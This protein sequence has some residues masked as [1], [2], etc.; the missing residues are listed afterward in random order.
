MYICLSSVT[1]QL[2]ASRPDLWRC[3]WVLEGKVSEWHIAEIRIYFF[4]MINTMKCQL[5]V[6]I[7]PT[8]LRC[9]PLVTVS[10]TRIKDSV[11]FPIL[12]LYMREFSH[13]TI[14]KV[15][16]KF[17]FSMLFCAFCKI[18]NMYIEHAWVLF[19]LDIVHLCSDVVLLKE[20]FC[21]MSGV[22]LSN[23]NWWFNSEM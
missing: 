18:S 17:A 12:F 9:R 5:F 1:H 16:G 22:V 23:S 20:R 10:S 19:C 14:L 13:Y 2:H 6:D 21:V 15:I 11:M 3:S 4:W 8:R 7:T